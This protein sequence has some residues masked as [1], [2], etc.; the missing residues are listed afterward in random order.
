MECS[1]LSVVY[2][3]LVFYCNIFNSR[4]IY[5]NFREEHL[6]KIEKRVKNYQV[7]ELNDPRPGKNLLVLD[8]DYTLFDHRSNAEKAEELMRPYLHE[9]LT[10]AYIDYD[11][12]IWCEYS[13]WMV[14]VFVI[15]KVFCKYFSPSS[16]RQTDNVIYPPK[17]LH[18]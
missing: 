12:V 1:T 11:I 4:I 9:F 18:Q 2:G 15:I 3:F 17:I 7:K 6:A 8:V 5:T 13:K 16:D 10:K 14:L